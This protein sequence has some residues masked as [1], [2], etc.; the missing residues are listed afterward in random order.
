MKAIIIILS[1]VL[2][3][4]TVTTT[5]NTLPDGTQV[6]VVAKSSDPVAIQA[7]LD[8]AKIITPVIERLSAEQKTTK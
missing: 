3:A 5:T 8:A 7:A 4:C 1:C 6:I 2:C